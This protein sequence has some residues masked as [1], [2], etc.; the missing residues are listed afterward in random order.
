[1]E[2]FISLAGLI[3]VDAERARIDKEMGQANEILARVRGKL[4]SPDFVAKAPPEVVAKER[5][6]LAELEAGLD[7]LR[8]QL[9]EL[10]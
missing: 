3:D 2:A 4:G 9:R 5:T 7:R 6:R 8:E 1:M 10:G